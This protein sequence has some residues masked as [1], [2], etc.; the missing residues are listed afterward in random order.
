MERL[1]CRRHC[2]ILLPYRTPRTLQ[3]ISGSML[4]LPVE[5]NLV[6]LCSWETSTCWFGVRSRLC[7]SSKGD[8]TRNNW[9]LQSS[10]HRR[11]KKKTQCTTIQVRL[12]WFV[13]VGYACVCVYVCTKVENSC[14]TNVSANVLQTS[15]CIVH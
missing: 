6:T 5:R 12:L 13:L 2:N 15:Y 10:N 7:R 14:S 3:W 8:A 1:H 11:R 4:L 9:L